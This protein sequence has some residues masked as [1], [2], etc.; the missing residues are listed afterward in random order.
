VRRVAEGVVEQVREAKLQEEAVP[1]ER[2]GRVLSDDDPTR[3]EVARQRRHGLRRQGAELQR[4]G[5]EREPPELRLREVEE[6][7]DDPL[8][9]PRAARDR[10]HQPLRLRLEPGRSPREQLGVPLHDRDRRLELVGRHLE[11][12]VLQPIQLCGLGDVPHDDDDPGD[13][14]PFVAHRGG[15]EREVRGRAPGG[16]RQRRLGERD[17][18]TGERPVERA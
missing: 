1:L 8:D 5:H 14:A 13:V 11:E 9:A 2:H 16:G 4:L 15:A 3:A 17:H 10:V 12:L 6:L 7:V 18:F